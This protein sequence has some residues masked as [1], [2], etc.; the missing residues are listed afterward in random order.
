M[1]SILGDCTR[2]VGLAALKHEYTGLTAIVIEGD[3]MNPSDFM[4]M[5]YGDIAK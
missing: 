3:L 5:D 4:H 2:Q 1:A